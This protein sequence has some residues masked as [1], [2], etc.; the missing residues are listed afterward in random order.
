MNTFLWWDNLYQYILELSSFVTSTQK[1]DYG[2]NYVPITSIILFKLH[3]SRK[4]RAFHSSAHCN[5]AYLNELFLM[6]HLL[7]FSIFILIKKKKKSTHTQNR[8]NTLTTFQHQIQMVFL[9]RL[10]WDLKQD[11]DKTRVA[12]EN[13]MDKG[14]KRN[15]SSSFF[16]VIPEN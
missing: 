4:T 6:L 1:S 3:F 13:R 10:V 16:L 15:K 5:S 2:L 7:Y 12:L 14:S 8:N 11:I 9:N